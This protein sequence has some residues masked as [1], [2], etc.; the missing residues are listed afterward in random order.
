MPQEIGEVRDA[1]QRSNGQES[2]L[3]HSSCTIFLHGATTALWE[4]RD[5]PL[6]TRN[7]FAALPQRRGNIICPSA[8]LRAPPLCG[9]LNCR[10]ML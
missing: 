3:L 9:A 2:N 5:S 4:N 8:A 6:R 7:V 1:S 10:S